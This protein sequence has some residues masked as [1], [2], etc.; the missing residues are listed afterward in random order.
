MFI[1]HV[2]LRQSPNS[3]F[4]LHLT[5]EITIFGK[6]SFFQRPW[7]APSVHMSLI[8]GWA[9][10]W[11]AWHCQRCCNHCCTKCMSPK[12]LHFQKILL[13][14]SICSYILLL[15]LNMHQ[16]YDALWYD[17]LKLAGMCT[18]IACHMHRHMCAH[19]LRAAGARGALACLCAEILYFLIVVDYSLFHGCSL[20][21]ACRL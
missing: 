21:A 10:F 9:S 8:R 14:V 19:L 11:T 12:C 2:C 3:I 15:L 1:S 18:P 6:L 4:A 5:L 17:S 20:S 16:S 7:M 13:S